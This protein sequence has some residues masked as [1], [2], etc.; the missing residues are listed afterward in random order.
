MPKQGDVHVVYH[1]AAKV[2]RVKVAR[3]TA[4]LQ[5]S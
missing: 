3:N 4:Y 5:S 1:N 2:W